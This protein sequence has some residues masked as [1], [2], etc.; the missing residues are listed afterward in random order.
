[1]AMERLEKVL[2]QTANPE[3]EAF[4]DGI[5]ALRRLRGRDI[6]VKVFLGW[7]EIENKP[8]LAPPI[9]G[10]LYGYQAV[11][12]KIRERILGGEFKSTFGRLPTE[13]TLLEQFK[14]GGLSVS[15]GTLRDG[16]RML[17]EEGLIYRRQGIGM[18]TKSQE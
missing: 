12:E 8:D 7:E 1:M 4:A 13:K 2:R 10:R 16:L 11:R 3:D 18:F 9:G 15:R 6:S 5:N 14:N 17:V